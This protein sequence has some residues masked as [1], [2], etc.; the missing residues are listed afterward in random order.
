MI[1][2]MIIAGCP[3][4]VPTKDTLVVHLK[5]REEPALIAF[6]GAI[7]DAFGCT[8]AL[9]GTT[10]VVGAPNDDAGI[11]AA[12]V[13]ENDGVA[14]DGGTKLIAS[15]GVA[16]DLFGTDV[17]IDGPVIVIGASMND[18]A[19]TDAGAAYVFRFDG[20]N[21]LEEE[22]FL[23]SDAVAGDAFGGAVGVS[24]N[25]AIVG[26][27]G[28]DTGAGAAY[29]FRFDPI[30]MM[31]AEEQELNASDANAG[32]GFG[33]DVAVF[34]DVALVAAASDDGDTGAVYVYRYD[35]VTMMWNEE[36]KLV[37][38][39][40][41]PSSAFGTSVSLNG[42]VAL[43]GAADAEQAYVFRY[44]EVAMVWNEEDILT[45]S[46]SVAGDFFGSAVA[47]SGNNAFVGA[48]NQDGGLGAV[49]IF[50]YDEIAMTWSEVD[51]LT[52]S[53]GEALD[54]F[55]SDVALD[56]ERSVVGAKG[57]D[58]AA[59]S[60]YPFRLLPNQPPVA[61]PAGPYAVECREAADGF[62]SLMLDGSGS[63]DP[64]GDPFTYFWSTLQAGATFDDPTLVQPTL[65]L[66]GVPEGVPFEVKLTVNDG[67]DSGEATT[68]VTL[69]D[70]IPPVITLIGESMLTL[71][72]GVDEYVEQGA[73]AEDLCDADVPVVI[74]GD[75][76]NTH[77]AGV[78]VVT[79]NAQDDAGND[80]VELTR[81]VEVV[82]TIPPELELSVTPS[83]LWPPNHKLVEVTVSAIATD[84]CDTDPAI[85]LVSVESSEPDN[86]IGDGNTEQDI[87]GADIG[88]ADFS[89]LLRAERSGPG[90]G[91]VYTLT[92]RATDDSGNSVESS[93]EVTVAH[94]QS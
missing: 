15:D 79:Y 4:S 90:E 28:A 85:T 41:S 82:D 47:V 49:Y 32:D 39:D 1:A 40:A 45:G 25:V 87:Q 83:M 23:A 33:G 46:D 37:A 52:A 93:T 27:A 56:G 89:I 72:C 80:A 51:K 74:G 31:W 22:K 61:N 6:D 19:D 81:T 44:D 3:Q 10:A 36:D 43:V 5:W 86:D 65:T 38:S 42:N 68:T 94:D 73:T 84:L 24:G 77:M 57:D 18:E 92:Y 8:V 60:A 55:G 88:A 70:T 78:Y 30:T 91:R 13:F 29:V 54:E 16:G 12:F 11:G 14:W 2:V 48:S 26:A 34:G 9:S 71:E 53:D 76:V 17:A 66:V 58:E 50:E 7:G 62:T 67:L 75:V 63:S 64:E 59:G 69:Q 21:W 20:A 35:A